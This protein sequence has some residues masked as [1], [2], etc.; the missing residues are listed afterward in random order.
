[1]SGKTVRVGTIVKLAPYTAR[2][3]TVRATGAKLRR[4]L[5]KGPLAADVTVRTFSGKTPVTT[6]VTVSR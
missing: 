1:V 6:K 5:A 4:A 2:G 3:V